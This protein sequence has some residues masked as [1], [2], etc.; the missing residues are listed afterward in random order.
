MRPDP[1]IVYGNIGFIHNFKRKFDDISSELGVVG[2]GE[3]DLRNAV[4]WGLGAAFALNEQMSMSFGFN[5]LISQAARTRPTGGDWSKL[6]GSDANAIA[7]NVGVTYSLGSST[8]L[9]TNFA[10]GLTPDA[11][12][13]AMSIRLP[14]SF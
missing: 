4:T 9:V 6:V 8:V 2:P 13:F 10:M 12:D 11:P 7:F 5:Q 1:A 14:Y 3:V